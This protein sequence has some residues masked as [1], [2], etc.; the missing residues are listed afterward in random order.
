MKL[1]T[2]LIALGLCGIF[3]TVIYSNAMITQATQEGD[4]PRLIKELI[5]QMKEKMEVN[6]DN[7]PTLIGEVEAY[8]LTVKDAPTVAVLHSMTAEMYQRYYQRNQWAINQRIPISGFIPE[9]I[10]EWTT[11][12]F[13]EKIKAELDASLQ[14]ADALQQ[15]PAS[16][17]SEIM[18]TGQDSPALRPTLYDFL[19][20]RALEIQPSDEIYKNLLAFRLTQPDKNPAVFVELAYLLYVRD[21]DYS[22]KSQAAYEASL[23]SLQKVY[24]DKGYSVEIVSAQLDVLQ[25]KEYSSVNR[26]SIRTLEYQLCKQTLARFPKY[27]RISII[28]NRL[29]VLEQQSINVQNPMTVYPGTNLEI[30]LSYSNITDVTVRVKDTLGVLINETSFPL[31]LRNSYTTHDTILSIPMDKTGVYEYLVSSSRTALHVTTQFTVSRLA[32]AT[33]STH[34]GQVEA[35]VTDYRSGKPVTG[36]TV[37]Y[38]SGRART[39]LQKLGEVK[40]DKNGLAL[41]PKNERIQYY[42]VTY[43]G[44]EA[45]QTTS[46]YARR[47]WGIQDEHIETV[48]S[49]FT[50]RGIYRPG[51][52][53][54]FKGIAYTS[55]KENPALVTNHSFEVILRDANYKE[56]A[57]KKFTTNEFG[58]F[59]GEFTLPRQTLTGT[60]TLLTGN[61]TVRVQVEEYKRPTFK[62]ELPALKDEIAFGDEVT[63]RGK[64]ETYSGVAL[65]SGEVSYLIIRRPLYF[66]MYMPG[67]R[68]E[69]VAEGKTTLQ[70]DGAFTFSFRPE[71][72]DKTSLFSYQSYEVIALVTDSKGETQEARLSVAVGDRSLA[73]F[74]NLGN[75]V[76]KDSATLI[77]SAKTLNGEA[78]PITG[79]YSIILLEDKDLKNL[80]DFK[81]LKTLATGKFTSGEPLEKK[82]LAGLPSGRL[83]LLVSATDS[84]GRLVEEKQDFVLYSKS[85]KRP[86]VASHTWLVTEAK[87]FLPGETIEVVFG[88]SDKVAYVLYDLYS[89]GISLARQRVELSN[90][91]RTFSI[92]TAKIQAKDITVAFTF[93]KEG[94]LYTEQK[95][96]LC[97]QPNR[98]LTIKPETFRDRLLPGS[99]ETWK[100]RLTDANAQPVLAEVL[101]G[102]YDASLDKIRPFDWRF[103]LSSYTVPYYNRFTEGGGMHTDNNMSESEDDMKAVRPILFDRLDWQGA[104]DFNRTRAGG[105]GNQ[106][107]MAYS[108]TPAAKMMADAGD[109]AILES[110]ESEMHDDAFEEASLESEAPAPTPPSLRTNFNETAFFFPSLLTDKEGN[111]VVS[112][113]LPESNTTWKLQAFAHTADLKYG[114]YTNEV[115]SQKPFMVLPNLPRFIRRGDEVNI[116]TQ[117]INLSEKETSGTVCLELFNPEN[118]ELLPTK[119]AHK[120]FTVQ[121]GA[122]STVSWSISLPNTSG[123]VGCRIVAD[124][125]SGSDGEQHLI[126]VLSNEILVT[127][128]TPFYFMGEGDKKVT[129]PGGKPSDTRRPLRMTLEFTGNPVWY[130]VQALPTLTEPAHNNVISWF[131]SYYSNTLAAFI[132]QSNP[133]IKKVIDQW[134]A[135]GGATSTLLSNLEKNEELKNILLEETPWVM[136]AQTETEQ[137]E[138]LALLFDVN[139]AAQ[140]R[141]AA[142]QVLLREQN[143]EGGWG[144]F[145][146]FY[147]NRSITL[148]ILNGMSQLTHLGA[149]QFNQQEKEM[150]F[151][152]LNYLDKEIQKDYADFKKLKNPPKDFL[153]GSIQLEYLYVR[154]AYRDIP[155]LGEAREAI[156]YYSGLAEKQWKKAGLREKGEIA[157]LMQRNGKKEVAQEIL[158]WLRKTATTSEEKGMYWANNRRENSFFVSP[159]DVHSLLMEV[160]Q[161]L[162]TDTKEIDRQKQWLLSQKQTQSWESVPSTVNALYSLLSTGSNWLTE[163]NRTTLQWGA[164][165]FR[166]GDGETA[167]GYIKESVNG[168]DITPA[169]NT[170][171]LHKEG[172]APAW[173]AVYN[174]YFE[175]MD[176]V[177]KQKGS[178]HIEKK[179]FLETNNG[180]QRQITPVSD[181]PLKVG[182]KVIVRI[183]I[184]TNREM[185]FVSLKDVRAGCFEPAR[186]ISGIG[187]AD[188]LRY[189]HAPKDAS[190]NFYFDLLPEGTYVLEYAA[191][192]SRS[193][194]YSAGLA[195]LQCLYAPEFVS[196]TEGTF[197]NI[198]R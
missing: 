96:F 106:A 33:R 60:F 104:L 108:A 139:R 23:D 29:A 100:F 123:L 183:T 81:V 87:D 76:N 80:E 121:A 124:S 174:Q 45:A 191:Y 12:L 83:R 37:N 113:T 189:Y 193:G 133:R 18:E 3:T 128:A 146:G 184:R 35:L 198:A 38:Y 9:D 58:S 147:P 67:S 138:R 31:S 6:Q 17:F 177:D 63:I 48:V 111:L 8:T 11:N 168:T 110:A 101:A 151:K 115:I 157:I 10:R 194:H 107:L 158:S 54:F 105:F 164:K 30:K 53:L 24:A 154:S 34:S 98:T 70:S 171:I 119:E 156:R 186:H 74:S 145:K 197:L 112:F 52:T 152:A 4:T 21:K 137:K 55:D 72:S 144:W 79:T 28:S 132:A 117:I 57:T 84:K 92:P 27:D 32:T 1:K 19:A 181:R 126:P 141:E 7:L 142:M 97:R 51:Q 103:A 134:T 5:G 62:I 143:E 91:N 26:D 16:S 116:S 170:L 82:L 65:T 13:T 176:K 163:D 153:P 161:T 114:L 56:I 69:Q 122:T 75:L 66:R 140:Q 61:N 173:G 64:A 192:V 59:H 135:E 175:Q 159:V 160:F 131:A 47:G 89:N 73:L 20:N 127:E 185:E 150:Q 102:M 14:P 42:K 167:T 125:E 149:I 90:E 118:E 178:L 43:P 88:T 44:D 187:T 39:N 46:I 120:S 179:L 15:T 68:E 196:H 188:R 130:A 40:T 77:V 182:D 136:D 85:D 148:N 172:K 190:E 78:V 94:K 93:I 86:P 36:A 49:L 99:W 95:S 71:K 2:I 180:T 41:L 155:E 195:T 166:P 50:D 162:G 129:I 165:A 169:L 25:N 109:A 22:E